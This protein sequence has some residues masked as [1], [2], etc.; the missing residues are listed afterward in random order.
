MTSDGLGAPRP[1]PAA[2][3]EGLREVL[4]KARVLI[5]NMDKWNTDVEKIIGKVPNTGF[6]R[7]GDLIAE[8]DAALRQSAKEGA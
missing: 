4:E 5:V 3:T 2:N 6:E 7:A 8:I 1:S